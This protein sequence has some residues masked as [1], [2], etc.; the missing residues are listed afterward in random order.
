MG[1]R[2]LNMFVGTA[3][4]GILHF[5]TYSYTNMANGGNA[6]LYQNIQYKNTL[7]KWHYVYFGYSRNLRE[8]FV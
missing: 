5:P 1:D 6:N 4:G 2:T 3:E 8:A 7:V